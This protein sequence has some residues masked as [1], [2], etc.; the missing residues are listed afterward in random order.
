[1]HRASAPIGDHVPINIDDPLGLVR[2]QYRPQ[3]LGGVH[4]LKLAQKLAQR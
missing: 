2:Y 3:G 1:M 4:A